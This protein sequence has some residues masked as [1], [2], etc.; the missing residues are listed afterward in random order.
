MLRPEGVAEPEEG[1]QT[2]TTV[3]SPEQYVHLF[4]HLSICL[5]G[6]C[7]F[8]QEL[9]FMPVTRSTHTPSISR[10]SCADLLYQVRPMP[11]SE[12]ESSLSTPVSLSVRGHLT[13][14]VGRGQGQMW[15]HPIKFHTNESLKLTGSQP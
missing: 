15:K 5:S 13:L 2:R 9:I 6:I 3:E 12:S 14:G 1:P 11:Y 10:T 7:G 8:D 4:V